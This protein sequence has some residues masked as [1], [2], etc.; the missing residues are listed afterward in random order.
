MQINEWVAAKLQ[1]LGNVSDIGEAINETFPTCMSK[2]CRPES[3]RDTA[4]VMP[5]PR[6]PNG[7]VINNLL[8]LCVGGDM[9][10]APCPGGFRKCLLPNNVPLCLAQ[11]QIWGLESCKLAGLLMHNL[12]KH[13]CPFNGSDAYGYSINSTDY[14]HF[15]R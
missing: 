1:G 15:V 12:P 11:K 2:C 14:Q 6:C 10:Y 8:G 4:L 9:G 13:Q 7:T 3:H 5:S